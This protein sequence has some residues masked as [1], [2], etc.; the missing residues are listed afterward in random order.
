QERYHRQVVCGAQLIGKS[1]IGR[2]PDPVEDAA[3]FHTGW[4]RGSPSLDDAHP[5]GRAAPPAAAHR[6]VRD[7]GESAR[8]QHT[9]AH[10]DDDLLPLG[11][12]DLDRLKT[13]LESPAHGSRHQYGSESS[14]K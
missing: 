10:W 2:R 9:E 6:G 1:Y 4:R 8:F 7:L 11:I 14:T 3:F 12:R 5:A 13:R